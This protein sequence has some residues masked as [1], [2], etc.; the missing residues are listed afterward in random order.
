MGNRFILTES[1]RNKIRKMYNLKEDVGNERIDKNL[2]SFDD[3]KFYDEIDDT[4]FIIE[5]T[6]TMFLNEEDVKEPSIV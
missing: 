2:K 4:H 1:E 5:F 6:F 3:I